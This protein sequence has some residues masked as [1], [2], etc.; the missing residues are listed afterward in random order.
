MVDGSGIEL[1]IPDLSGA[2]SDDVAVPVLVANFTAVAGVEIHITFDQTKITVDSVTSA[3]LSD[4]TVN[5]VN[6]RAHLIW[7]DF[8]HPVTLDDGDTLMFIYFHVMPTATGD[9][10]LAFMATCELVDEIGDPYPLILTGGKVV[11]TPTDVDDDS[12]RLPTEFGLRQNY[13][14][15]FNPSTTISYTVDRAMSLM[16]E[17]FNVSGQVVDRIDLGHQSP[18]IYSFVYAAGT[19]PSG[20]Y[21]YRLTGEGLSVAKQMILVK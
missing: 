16:F 8:L 14:N 11:V 9:I 4:P 1:T 7:E 13:P 12:G 15:P 10:P 5:A 19:L 3:R 18:G 21:T 6:G 2:P 20:I 17:V